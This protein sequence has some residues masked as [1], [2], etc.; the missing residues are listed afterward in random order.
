VPLS[1]TVDDLLE[2][3]AWQR[4]KW[5]DFFR[6]QPSRLALSGGP[7]GDGRFGIV[8]DAVKHIFSAELRY[9]QR[10]R[11]VPLSDL[12]ALDST[13]LALLESLGNHSRGSLRQL[14]I[15]FPQQEWDSPREFI[16]L[17]MR[18][19]TTPKKI[20]VHTLMHEIRHWAQIATL[21]RINGD[22][23]AFQDFL[24]SPVWGET[25]QGTS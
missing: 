12:A 21:C 8:G 17:T 10:L 25:A 3:T 18:V 13:D 16:I 6:E 11:N 14:L 20:V 19:V 23:P 4:G 15:E 9:V 24:A 7:H 2:Y 5:F 22:A 1:L